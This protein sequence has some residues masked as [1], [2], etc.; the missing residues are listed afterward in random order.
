MRLSEDSE[1]VR[2]RAILTRQCCSDR[3]CLAFPPFTPSRNFP[4]R[5]ARKRPECPT[6]KTSF[7]CDKPPKELVAKLYFAFDGDEAEK[8][9]VS[10]GEGGENGVLAGVGERASARLHVRAIYHKKITTILSLLWTVWID[11]GQQSCRVG[12]RFGSAGQD[13]R[14]T[15]L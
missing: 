15:E 8:E 10:C 2:Y 1:R 5:R 14:R 13:S 9:W 12:R 7:D 3:T 6:C 4:F 11:I